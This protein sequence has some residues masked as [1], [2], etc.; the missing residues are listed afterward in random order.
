[1]FVQNWNTDIND[2]IHARGYVLYAT[3]RF[4]PY[5]CMI[6]I[7]KL[8]VSWSR[9]RVSAHRLDIETGI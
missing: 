9:L 5:L 1:M 4:Q 7:E 6:N 2:S 3:F 8:R